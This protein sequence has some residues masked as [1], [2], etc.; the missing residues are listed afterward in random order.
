MLRLWGSRRE[1]K[2][3][4]QS[5]RAGK[6]EL[7]GRVLWQTEDLRIS[8]FTETPGPPISQKGRLRQRRPK[9]WLER[10]LSV[11]GQLRWGFLEAGQVTNGQ[12]PAPEGGLWLLLFNS[13]GLSCLIGPMGAP[14]VCAQWSQQPLDCSDRPGVGS[15][16][17]GETSSSTSLALVSS[18]TK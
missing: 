10:P 8:Q 7:A 9:T 17:P 14:E 1:G 15:C 5:R 16:S 13:L 2:E 11:V 3:A 6:G 4:V 12:K 18:G